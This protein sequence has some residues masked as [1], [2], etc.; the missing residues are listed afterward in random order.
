[1]PIGIHIFSIMVTGHFD[2]SSPVGAAGGI[3]ESLDDNSSRL[4]WT[5][6]NFDRLGSCRNLYCCGLSIRTDS[7]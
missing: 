2:E 6:S 3:F 1:L 4:I 7:S 5:T